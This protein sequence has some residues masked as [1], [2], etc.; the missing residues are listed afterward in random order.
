MSRRILRGKS[1]CSTWQRY[2]LRVSPEH[3]RFTFLARDDEPKSTRAFI[4]SQTTYV[5]CLLIAYSPQYEI[6][7]TIN[8]MA[9]LEADVHVDYE[10]QQYQSLEGGDLKTY[11]T[12]AIIAFVLSTIVLIEKVITIQYT[13]WEGKPLA[14]RT[15][16]VCLGHL[17][18][19]SWK[20]RSR[21]S[22]RPWT[23]LT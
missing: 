12:V 3:N 23:K 15:L 7:S 8:I 21:L 11:E 18:S 14:S 17:A 1:Y 10:I 20:K 13:I 5:N 2:I 22:S 19:L 9:E 4:D 6:V 16:W